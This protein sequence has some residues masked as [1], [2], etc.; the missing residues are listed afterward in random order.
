MREVPNSCGVLAFSPADGKVLV[1]GVGLDYFVLVFNGSD[2]LAVTGRDKDATRS[3]AK[4]GSQVWLSEAK[5]L[6]T[7]GYGGASRLAEKLLRDEG[8]AGRLP[9]GYL[10]KN[11]D[12][13]DDE[14]WRFARIDFEENS[15]RVGI[16]LFFVGPGVGRNDGLRSTEYLGI[17]VSRAH[18]LALLPEPT[19]A[20]VPAPSANAPAASSSP[21]ASPRKNVSEAEL[22]NCILT[23]KTE[24]PNDPPDEEELWTEVERRL[25]ATVSRDRIRQARDDVAP[26]FKLPPGRPRKSAQ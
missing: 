8:A 11:G 10:R 2:L 20:E 23:I 14:F 3:S 25:D 1:F 15:A 9:W 17:W 12:A 21:P 13:A 26:E 24:R 18:V 16:T 19:D 5:A 6:L 7:E 22:R 4:G